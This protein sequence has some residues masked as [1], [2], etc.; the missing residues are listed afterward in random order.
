MYKPLFA[1][2]LATALCSGQRSL[3]TRYGNLA[4]D[5]LGHCIRAIGDVD[6]DGVTDLVVAAHSPSGG[7]G[8]WYVFV[9][10]GRDGHELFR[11]TGYSVEF[12]GASVS[13]VGDVDRDGTPDYA[14]GVTNYNYGRVHVHSGKTGAL[15]FTVDGDSQGYAMGADIAS[16]GDVNGDGYADFLAAAPQTASG[17]YGRVHVISGKLKAILYSVS[18]AIGSGPSSYVPMGMIRSVGD[19]N[20][21]G[22]PDFGVSDMSSSNGTT[23]GIG[24]VRIH[25]GI[26]GAVLRTFSNP[27]VVANT[28]AF[29]CAFARVGDVDNDGTRDWLVT[30]PRE[31]IPGVGLGTARVYSGATGLVLRTHY[32]AVPLAAPTEWY[33]YRAANVGDLDLDGVDDY[34]LSSLSHEGYGGANAG[35][36]FVFSAKTGRPLFQLD[37]RTGKAQLGFSL[38]PAGD[39]DSDGIPDI[40]VGAPGEQGTLS[41]Q[42]CLRVLSGRVVADALSLPTRCAGSSL[43]PLLNAT[44]PLLGTLC[45]IFGDQA[46]LN[47]PGFLLISPRPDFE[48]NLGLPGCDLWIDTLRFAVLTTVPGNTPSWSVPLAIPAFPPFSGIDIRL[49]AL[50]GPTMGP[51][52][53]DLS[54]GLALKLGY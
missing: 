35:T 19:V 8:T 52:G 30:S 42:G 18:G 45:R 47:T 50:Y 44:R 6:A 40:I 49:Q 24:K 54:N 9:L 37:G 31:S 14:I 20:G 46:P 48:T 16:L 22:V 38:E 1:A 21:D 41:A 4:Y 3:L 51:F 29:G 7:S 17:P 10:S 23:N 12:F 28:G 53:V 32:G 27:A 15:L 13:G 5:G 33:G 25:S 11:H 2:L 39:M 36:V 43:L 26:N 34:A